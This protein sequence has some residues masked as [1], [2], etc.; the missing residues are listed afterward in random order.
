MSG[1]LQAGIG[2][3]DI[4]P[5][6][7]GNLFGYR[8]DVFSKSVNDGLTVTAAAFCQGATKAMLISATL[9]L[10]NTALSD[11]IRALV[12]EKTGIPNVIL[13][14]THTHSGPNTCGI[15][16]WGGV[17]DEY[18]DSVLVPQVIEAAKEA[19][20]N[21][22]PVLLGV[23]A[24]QSRV[25]MNR[26]RHNADGSINLGQSPWG[27]YDPTM[28]VLRFTE[29]GGKPVI[30]I[31]HYGCH[32]T[33]AGMNTEITRDWA[34][35]MLDRLEKE[36]GAPAM[37][38]NGA[39][40]DVGPR[41]SNGQ[42]VGDISYAMELGGIAALDATL[43][44]R[45]AKNVKPVNFSVA[46]DNLKLPLKAR[47][48]YEEAKKRLAEMENSEVNIVGQVRQ[49]YRNI[50]ESYDKKMKEK[51]FFTLPQTLVA[52]GGVVFVPFPFEIFSEISMRLREYS[53]FE[54][55][56]CMSCT[57]GSNGY[58]PSQDQLCRGGYEID[59]FRTGR[60]QPFAD[61]TDDN[62]INENL[63]LLKKILV[64]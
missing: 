40:G 29:P 50:I 5:A 53:P 44:W 13:S 2:R 25:G 20:A 30:N 23:G 4:T 64:A 39:Q 32:C 19:A 43:A 27:L 1:Q 10:F 28:T 58:L 7:G 26:R 18:C 6:V 31:I 46:S 21:L 60:V 38:I 51:A 34:G 11:K 54:H 59:F 45:N 17:D 16:G 41:L 15:T 12:A 55:T 56:L 8:P 33:A 35:V 22:K 36:A 49:Y 3:R 37:F 47:L 62:I 14:A 61:N 48:P 63:K 57:N 42:T 24:V 9:G 52:V